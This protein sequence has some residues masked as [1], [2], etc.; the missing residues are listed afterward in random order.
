[1]DYSCILLKL[2][3]KRMTHGI[4]LRSVLQKVLAPTALAQLETFLKYHIAIIGMKIF[5]LHFGRLQFQRPIPHDSWTI[6]FSWSSVS[7]RKIS[8][9]FLEREK[10]WKTLPLFSKK[11][12]KAF[13]FVKR[14]LSAH[15]TSDWIRISEKRNLNVKSKYLSHTARMYSNNKLTL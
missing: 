1:M 2:C 5:P 8:A 12:K 13:A 15:C 7:T 10:Q 9:S 6:M 4:T 14:H 11:K 3:F